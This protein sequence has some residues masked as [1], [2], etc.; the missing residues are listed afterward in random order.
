MSP[1][2]ARPVVETRSGPVRGRRKRGVSAFKGIP[3]A[4][5]PFGPNRLLAP[6]PVVPWQEIRDAGDY[7]PTVPKA[8]YR[9]P[10]DTLLE[11]PV[12]EGVECLNLNVWTPDHEATHLPVLVWIHGGAY[13]NGTG[14]IALY[15]GTSFARHGAVC[16]TLNYRLGI[17]GFLLL[18]DAPNNRGLLDILSALDWVQDNIRRFGGNP[19]KVTLF[20]QSAGAMAVITLLAMPRA[21]GL[22]RR[23]I[24]QSGAG[25]RVVAYPDAARVTRDI[26]KRVGTSP[27]REG[28]SAVPLNR[29]YAAQ[30]Q[31][32]ISIHQAPARWGGVG[33]TMM[34][35]APTIDRSTLPRDP[36]EAI[37]A[38]V[39]AQVDLLIGNNSDEQ[40]FFLVPPGIIDKIGPVIVDAALRVYG[41]VPA[42]IRHA[43][44]TRAG[45]A[46]ELLSAAATDF[47][48]RV[49]DVRLAEARHASGGK[50]WMYEFAWRSPQFD[51]RLAACHYLEVPFV[52]DNLD[53][54]GAH[55]LTGA[56]P[57]QHLADEMHGRWLAF[58]RTGNPGWAR[59]TPKHRAVMVFDEISSVTYD[60]RS[61]E[62]AAWDN[63]DWRDA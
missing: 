62:R 35:F 46:G 39:G 48:F 40:L 7:G 47:F 2:P 32:V 26:A 9:A 29:L 1:T 15:D 56:D 33:I 43:Y 63:G 37:A 8:A 51:G 5:P 36:F 55:E 24:A 22:F 6:Q 49:P 23:A 34:P 3:Y 61:Q 21:Q 53:A 16:V 19:R 27:T 25:H 59:Y 57:P 10:F 20:G 54:V 31:Q 44:E 13:R 28:I 45:S 58:A 38:G 41:A 60:P 14:A 42:R 12:I 4:A 50:T 18:D 11:E 52:F 17:D 30:Y